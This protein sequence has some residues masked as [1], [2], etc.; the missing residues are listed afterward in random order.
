MMPGLGSGMGEQD[1][2]MRAITMSL[3][4]NV[5][6]ST[7]ATGETEAAKETSYQVNDEDN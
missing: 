1:D 2:L 5:T 6:V 7:E 4:E 3:G